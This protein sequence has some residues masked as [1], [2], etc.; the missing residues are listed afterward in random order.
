MTLNKKILLAV[1]A[2]GLSTAALA[3]DAFA[4]DTSGLNVL[5][6]TVARSAEGSLGSVRNSASTVEKMQCMF[7]ATAATSSVDAICQATDA[8]GTFVSCTT[9]SA[10]LIQAIQ[11]IKGDSHLRFT[12]NTD[13]TCATVKVQNG[14]QWAPKDL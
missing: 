4:G 3:T 5:I 10:V 7:T 6:S 2:V 14:S 9:S 8:A 13:G 1:A 11:S 12:W